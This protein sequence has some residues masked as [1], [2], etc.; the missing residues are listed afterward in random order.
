[1]FENLIIKYFKKDKTIYDELATAKDAK[2]MYNLLSKLPNPDKILRSYGNG[3]NTLRDLKTNYQVGTCIESRKSGVTSKKWKLEKQNCSDKEFDFYTELFKFIDI[4][5]LIEDILE[6]PLF[7]YQPIEILYDKDGANIIPTKIVAKPQE[8]F[9]YNTKDNNFYFDSKS[10][11]DGILI[12]AHN[13]KFLLP[14]HRATYLN[15]YGECLLSKTFWN[16]VFMNSGMEFW[17]TFMEQYGMPFMIGKYDRNKPT[18]EREELFTM[19][20]RMVQNA[21]GVIPN[22]GSIEIINPDKNGSNTVYKDFITKCENNISKVVLG[23]TLTTDIGTTGSYA[24]AN[25]HQ[26]VREDL[27]QNDVRLVES[28][29]NSLILKIHSLNFNNTDLPHFSLYDE[30]ELDQTLA[31]RDNKLKTLGI[32]FTKEYIKKA[33]GLEDEDFNLIDE[34]KE[35]KEFSDSNNT[36]I[37]TIDTDDFDKLDKLMS[38]FKAEDY[39]NVINDALKPIV[40]LFQQ[41]RDADECME[42][43]AEVYP[44]M[45]TEK[46]EET[47][48]KVIFL[49]EL[50]G[51]INE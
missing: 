11:N 5:K 44:E 28:C 14:T 17:S 15:P 19:L 36:E 29:I 40:E 47:L 50:M 21:V 4:N 10:N 16:V 51:R 24:A 1:M 18:A 8:W 49:A 30:E 37:K 32:N 9:Y 2:G 43:L 3:F 45:N 27:I 35:I 25:T 31:E 41:S 34:T 7:G 26:Q 12:E 13:P 48:T 42:K 23:Q 46:L 39:E 38:S 22:D 6:A 20:K 33:Y